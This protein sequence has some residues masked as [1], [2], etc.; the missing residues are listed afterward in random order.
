MPRFY[1]SPVTSFI[2]S[3]L[4]SITAGFLYADYGWHNGFLFLLVCIDIALLTYTLREYQG[5][6]AVS[7]LMPMVMNVLVLAV[8]SVLCAFAGIS[9]GDGSWDAASMAVYFVS[10]M[11]FGFMSVCLSVHNAVTYDD[12]RFAGPLLTSLVV[13]G[14]M[15]I[16]G[17]IAVAD[18]SGSQLL[19]AAGYVAACVIVGFL[20]MWRQ[21]SSSCCTSSGLGLSG[22]TLYQAKIRIGS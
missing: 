1:F 9:L 2:L 20:F 21:C 11:G 3:M 18:D 15:V 14:I 19:V 4:F 5:T 8:V 22:T 16:F 10:V 12:A 13:Y 6:E 7:R 17:L